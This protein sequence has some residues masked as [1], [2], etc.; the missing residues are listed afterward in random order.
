MSVHQFEW[1]KIYFIDKTEL[2]YRFKDNKKRKI[3]LI[4]EIKF[5]SLCSN[6]I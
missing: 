6:N 3:L 1:R 4:C 5:I 2:S